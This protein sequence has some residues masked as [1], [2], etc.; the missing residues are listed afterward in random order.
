MDEF[1]QR[2]LRL[3]NSK[4]TERNNHGRCEISE[5]EKTDV[6]L[7]DAYSRAVITVAEAVGPAIVSIS[8]GKQ[9]QWR[10]LEQIGAGSGV[11]S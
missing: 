3:I 7:L 4:E 2:A 8:V 10:E 9:S 6:E 11:I 5:T 1:T